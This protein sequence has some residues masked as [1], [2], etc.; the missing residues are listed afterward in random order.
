[1]VSTLSDDSMKTE[2]KLQSELDILIE[3]VD[4][5]KSG[6]EKDNESLEQMS[7]RKSGRIKSRVLKEKKN[8]FTI[9]YRNC[10]ASK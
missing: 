1:M 5:I 10:L 8:Y 2:Q 3:A 9:M 7:Q 4:F 6:K